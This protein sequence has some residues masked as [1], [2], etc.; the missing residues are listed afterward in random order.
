METHCV[1]DSEKFVHKPRVCKITVP[2]HR[3]KIEAGNLEPQNKPVTLGPLNKPANS[4]PLN[5]TVT[6][7]LLNEPIICAR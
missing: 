5:K 2:R 1:L 6:L 3:L 7:G 4:G